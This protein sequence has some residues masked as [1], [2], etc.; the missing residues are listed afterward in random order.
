MGHVMKDMKTAFEENFLT[1][2]DDPA[3]ENYRLIWADAW[4]AAI[5]NHE[6]ADHNKHD[7]K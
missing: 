4:E 5:A 2:W 1:D 6:Y 7:I 3:M